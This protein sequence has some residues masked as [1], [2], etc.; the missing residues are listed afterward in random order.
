MLLRNDGNVLPVSSGAKK[1]VV[2]G[3]YADDINDQ[4]GGW[5]VG[6]QGVPDGVTLPGT[7]VLQGIKEA[8]P[9]GTQVVQAKTADDA[10]DAGQGRRPH[11]RGGR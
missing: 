5:T 8:A 6:W 10:V 4:A 11:G 3:S 7:T 2:A 9:S 1:I